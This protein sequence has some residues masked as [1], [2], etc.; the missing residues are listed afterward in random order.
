MLVSF[1]DM[2]S[3]CADLDDLFGGSFGVEA[4]S[5]HGAGLALGFRL[6]ALKWATT[7]HSPLTSLPTT[8]DL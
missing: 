8:E 2:E 1:S 6:L 5:G 3:D 7:T 4:R